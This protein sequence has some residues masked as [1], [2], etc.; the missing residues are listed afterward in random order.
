MSKKT[1]SSKI[2]PIGYYPIEGFAPAYKK[3][4]QPVQYRKPEPK[5]KEPVKEQ[6]KPVEKKQN[7]YEGTPAY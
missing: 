1:F 5:K 4:V 2:Y 6:P 3:P 7:V